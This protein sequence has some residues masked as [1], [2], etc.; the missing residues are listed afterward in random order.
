MYLLK[1]ESTALAHPQ[2]LCW[3]AHWGKSSSCVTTLEGV[4]REAESEGACSGQLHVAENEWA[5]D[6][7]LW[8]E[9]SRVEGEVRQNW[10]EM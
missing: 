6:V 9:D 7:R 1:F 3:G 8:E 5:L 4:S 2:V 10:L